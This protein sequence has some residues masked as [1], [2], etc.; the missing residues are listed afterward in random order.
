MLV[1]QLSVLVLALPLLSYYG[2]KNSV[3]A[4]VIVATIQ[5][6]SKVLMTAVILKA[7]YTYFIVLKNCTYVIFVK[8]V[9]WVRG[10]SLYLHGIV[11]LLVLLLK[12]EHKNT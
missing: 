1:W 7:S 2:N 10:K 11:Y 6:C 3:V 9:V 12:H 4:A 5:N 8:N